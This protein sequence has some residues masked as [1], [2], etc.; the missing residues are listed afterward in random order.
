MRLAYSATDARAFGDKRPSL[1]SI[2]SAERMPSGLRGQ[3]RSGAVVG[4][5]G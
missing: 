5:C 2:A 1:V 3:A 4:N